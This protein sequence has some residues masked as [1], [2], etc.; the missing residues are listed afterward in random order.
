MGG[1]GLKQGARDCVKPSS[2]LTMSYV[3]YRKRKNTQDFFTFPLFVLTILTVESSD[4]VATRTLS[5]C[6]SIHVTEPWWA[7]PSIKRN[8][9]SCLPAKLIIQIKKALT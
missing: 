9:T 5:L 4:P 7:V 8:W 1:K 3:I 2:L 6:P